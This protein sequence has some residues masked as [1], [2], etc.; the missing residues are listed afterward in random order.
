[1]TAFSEKREH[2]I[3]LAVTIGSI[4]EWYE[5]YLF[6]FWAPIISKLFFNHPS[7][8]VNLIGTFFLFA[9]GFLARPFGGIIFGRIGDLLGRKKSLILSIVALAIPSFVMGMLPTYETIGLAAPLIFAIT[10]LLQALPAG[11]ELPGA[12]CYLY[13]STHMHHRRYMTSWGAVG[14]QIGIVISILECFLLELLLTPEQ[15]ISWGWRFSFIFG[16]VIALFGFCLRYRLYETPLYKDM[17]RHHHVVRQPILKVVNQYKK[18]ILMGIGFCLSNSVGFYLI[19]VLFPI[20]FS[21]ILN[22]QYHENLVI[23]LCIMVLTTLP[24][25]FIGM[26][27]DRYSNKKI[28]IGCS[29]VMIVLLYPL[30]MFIQNNAVGLSLIS[31]IVFILAFTCLT[32]LIPYRFAALFPTPVRYTCV[33]ISYNLVDGILGGFSPALALYVL[34][35]TQSEAICYWMV[36]VSALISLFSFFKI[37]EEKEHLT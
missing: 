21:T 12:F 6:V 22:I 27:G 24:L 34:N 35:R 13:E 36:F 4:L 5:I 15:M 8:T 23:S 9:V 3:I 11:G 31:A 30:Y 29:L 7:E 37:K 16:G 14:N 25:P 19:S 18:N 10:R 20:C 1:M 32:A 2:S 26:L 28:L 33:G 17:E